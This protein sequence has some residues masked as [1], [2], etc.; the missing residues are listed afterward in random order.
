[1]KQSHK[2]WLF[3]LAILPLLFTILFLYLYLFPEKYD[4]AMVSTTSDPINLMPTVPPNIL[5]PTPHINIPG[6]MQQLMPASVTFS[7]PF[8]PGNPVGSR[9]S[10]V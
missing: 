1:M 5:P 8:P 2:K 3:V 6:S 9:S 7:T 4:E 10:L